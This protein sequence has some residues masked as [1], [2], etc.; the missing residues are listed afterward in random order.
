M[1]CSNNQSTGR[2]FAEAKVQY[3]SNLVL[4]Y[5]QTEN[6]QY[7]SSIKGYNHH[8]SQMFYHDKQASTDSEK[9]QLFNGYFYSAFSSND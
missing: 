4:T 5:T 2:T 6:F 8:P 7:I 1:Q 9:A 3:E